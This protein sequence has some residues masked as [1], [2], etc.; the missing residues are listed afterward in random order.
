MLYKRRAKVHQ[1]AGDVA[2]ESHALNDSGTGTAS[3]KINVG[4]LTDDRIQRL[5]AIGFVWSLRDD[6]IKHYE[7]LKAY[8]AE[9]GD[10]NVPARYNPNRKLGIWVSAQRQQYKSLQSPNHEIKKKSNSLTPERIRLLEELGFS[11][12]IRSRDT[13]GESWNLRFAQLQEYHAKYGN[14]LVPSRYSPIPELGVWV[15]T[16]RTQ[17]RLY[18]AAM[19]KGQD[20]AVASSMTQQRI[21]LLESIGF[22]WF[23]RGQDSQRR[24]ASS[25]GVPF[26]IEFTAPDPDQRSELSYDDEAEANSGTNGAGRD[27]QQDPHEDAV[28]VTEL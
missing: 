20:V 3:T 2:S 7:E 13:L 19:E 10:C 28:R 24:G 11:W 21:Q 22:A 16:Q 9:H 8:K 6:W 23:V 25:Q 12:S 18:S 5:E 14:C 26:L 17:Y 4:R 15:G 27:Q 1:S